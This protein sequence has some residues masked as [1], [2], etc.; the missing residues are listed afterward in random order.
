MHAL[1][2]FDPCAYMFNIIYILKMKNYFMTTD[3][4]KYHSCVSYQ[5]A[6]DSLNY[7]VDTCCECDGAYA[8]GEVKVFLDKI[9]SMMGGQIDE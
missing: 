4:S 9:Y 8:G 5:D 6:I 2:G 7:L 3:W 1:Q